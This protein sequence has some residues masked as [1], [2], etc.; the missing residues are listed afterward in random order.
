MS[1]RIEQL[2]RVDD[3]D[4]VFTRP[5]VLI[6]KHSARCWMCTKTLKVVRAFAGAHSDIDI[7]MVDVLGSRDVSDEIARRIDLK[8]ESPQAILFEDGEAVWHANHMKITRAA[9]R[10][11]A[12]GG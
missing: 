9:L 11:S 12:E 1:E 2:T 7:F 10:F 6:Y 3:L 4:A 5:R 8:H